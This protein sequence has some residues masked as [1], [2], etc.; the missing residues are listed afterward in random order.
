[1]ADPTGDYQFSFNGWVFGGLGSGVQVLEVDGLEDMPQLRV[2]DDT[3]GYQDG[4]FTGRDFLGGRTITFTLQIMN[5]SAGT[6]QTY[7]AQLKTNLLYQQAGTGVL[8]FQ[9]PG[10]SVQRVGARIRKRALKV[11]PDYVYGK[12]TATV[13]M[14][15]PDPR[16]YADASQGGV[17]TPGANVGRVY[18]RTYNLVYT[19]PLSGSSAFTSFTNNGNVTVYPTFTITGPCNYPIIVNSTTGQSIP[20]N[21]NLSASETIVIDPDLR[22]VTIN[23]SPARNVVSNTAQ[24]FGFNPGSTTIGIVVTTFT[25]PSQCVV[26]YRD[27]YV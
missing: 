9:L 15:C 21:Y 20:I 1:M 11:D 6:M 16:I 23:G 8:Q 18:D 4:M 3:R 2:Q 25:A 12:S 19:T 7:L 26:A 27:G 22:A 24:W 17:L 10:R 5:D 13:E 14:F